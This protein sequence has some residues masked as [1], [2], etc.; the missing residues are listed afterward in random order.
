MADRLA[1]NHR[2]STR[3]QRER[4]RTQWEIS[5]A[6]EHLRRARTAARDGWDGTAVDEFRSALGHAERAW[7]RTNLRRGKA[8]H[9]MHRAAVLEK[10]P[11]ELA[12]LVRRAFYD[13]T[14]YEQFVCRIEAFPPV[15]E[16][17]EQ[18]VRMLLHGAQH[19]PRNKRRFP[20]RWL[21]KAVLPKPRLRSGD[22]VAAGRFRPGQVVSIEDRQPHLMHLSYGDEEETGFP[23]H[24]RRW[25]KVKP[26]RK[27]PS[28]KDVFEEGG[29]IRHAEHGFGRIAI[30]R[31][32]SLEVAFH[33]RRRRLVP[34]P[35][36]EGIVR[37]AGPDPVDTRP[38]SEWIR[39]G[40]WVRVDPWGEG[41]VLACYRTEVDREERDCL[42]ILVGDQVESL[43][44]GPLKPLVWSVNRPALDMAAPWNAR[45]L[46]FWLQ[47]GARHGRPV[48]R[49]CGYPVLGTDFDEGLEPLLCLIC[50]WFDDGMDE[51]EASRVREGDKFEWIPNAGYSLTEAR[52]SFLDHG[53][54]FPLDTPSAER[55]ADPATERLALREALDSL[56]HR[57]AEED[58]MATWNE[59]WRMARRVSVTLRGIG[60]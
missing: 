21:R 56:K 45:A 59:I 24:A 7:C 53:H 36:L 48:C 12:S 2:R 26:P 16:L 14:H 19:P 54:V 30:L 15:V 57:D 51:A 17:A 18:A 29:W 32:T 49:C 44:I 38:V 40:D 4:E 37:V 33:D 6:E 41:V 20:A 43:A 10:A 8:A 27:L 60:G 47:D 58:V 31:H 42:A 11:E 39:I 23:P 34:S 28:L 50:G 1:R 35:Y 3:R 9:D 55:M 22:W 5:G 25:A 52:A 46:W 13:L